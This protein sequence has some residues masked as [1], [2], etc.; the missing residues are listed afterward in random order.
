MTL[1][2]NMRELTFFYVDK[3]NIILDS[4]GVTLEKIPSWGH[5]RVFKRDPLYLVLCIGSFDSN[6]S[7]FD[8]K[9]K[10]FRSTQISNKHVSH[11]LQ[12]HEVVEMLSDVS[13]IYYGAKI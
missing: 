3:G 7:I 10:L 6:L 9:G 13:T 12:P 11:K 8:A 5:L 2:D 4:E 1:G